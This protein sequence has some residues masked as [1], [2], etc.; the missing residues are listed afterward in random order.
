MF[1]GAKL[2]QLYV[3]S[4]GANATPGDPQAGGLF[5]IQGLGFRGLPEPR[6]RG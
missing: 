5:L 3:T 4:I 1:A 6:F 2:D